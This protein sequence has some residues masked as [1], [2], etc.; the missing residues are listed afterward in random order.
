MSTEKDDLFTE[1]VRLEYNIA[2]CDRDIDTT[3]KVILNLQ[4]T[5]KGLLSNV[6]KTKKEISFNQDSLSHLKSCKAGWLDKLDNVKEGIKALEDLENNKLVNDLYKQLDTSRILA[7]MSD[8]ESESVKRYNPVNVINLSALKKGNITE[9]N[10]R[11]ICEIRYLDK[12]I[13]DY[14]SDL[15][16][17][18]K[19]GTNLFEKTLLR[20]YCKVN[21]LS[22]SDIYNIIKNSRANYPCSLMIFKSGSKHTNESLVTREQYL[23]FGC[24]TGN[25]ILQ[26]EENDVAF[27]IFVYTYLQTAELFRKLFNTGTFLSDIELSFAM[28]EE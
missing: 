5:I 6:E 2:K 23:D 15:G 28:K 17:I 7:S 16:G 18:S 27:N 22:L 12:P 9:L 24:R 11:F 20:L 3:C 19:F 21:N 14:F 26:L 1:K 10:N 4:D 13:S 25:N 8:L